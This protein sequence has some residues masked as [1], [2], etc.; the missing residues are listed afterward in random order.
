MGVGELVGG[1]R[2]EPEQSLPLGVFQWP[3]GAHV[4]AELRVDLD[5]YLKD[6]E[7]VRILTTL[8]LTICTLESDSAYS[9]LVEGADPGLQTLR[10]R[11]RQGR[12]RE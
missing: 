12:G 3:V 8:E 7:F 6:D 9:G 2:Q 1:G 5:G 4:V 10:L 11:I